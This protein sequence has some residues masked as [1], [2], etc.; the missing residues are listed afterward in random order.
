MSHTNKTERKIFFDKLN[1]AQT[2]KQTERKLT[3]A[4]T[5]AIVWKYTNTAKAETTTASRWW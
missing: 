4:E 5:L 1:A 3:E 2:V